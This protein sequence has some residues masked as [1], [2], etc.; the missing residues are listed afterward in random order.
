MKKKLIII[1]VALSAAGVWFVSG[2][3]KVDSCLDSGGRWNAASKVCEM[4]AQK[5]VN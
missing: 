5:A 3:L 4:S 2:W 1:L